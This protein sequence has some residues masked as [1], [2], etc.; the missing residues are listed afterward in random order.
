MIGVS[1]SDYI[2]IIH[3]YDNLHHVYSVHKKTE[4]LVWYSQQ[5]FALTFVQ[6][7]L[8]GE[9]QKTIIKITKIENNMHFKQTEKNFI[10]SKVLKIQEQFKSLD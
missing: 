10:T 6:S 9:K 7:L 1:D 5:E 3:S 2:W 4:L 8:Q